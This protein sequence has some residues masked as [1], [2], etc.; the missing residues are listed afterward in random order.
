MK[1]LVS[2]LGKAHDGGKTGY[3]QT[4]Y[5]FD[6]DHAAT[7][8]YFGLA[9]AKYLKSDR[10]IVLGTASSMWG[11]F[12][13]DTADAPG[14]V[15]LD[16]L[17]AAEDAGTVNDTLLAAF[18]PA[19]ERRVGCPVSLVVIPHAR[20]A[21]EQIGI[22]ERLAQEISEGDTIELD[23]TH[24]FRHLP[25]M[26]LVAARYLSKVRKAVVKE[27]YYGAWEM[28][29]AADVS[30]VLRLSGLLSLLDWVDAIASYDKDGDYGVFASLLEAEGLGQDASNTMRRAAFFERTNNPVKAREAAAGVAPQIESLDSP[31][32]GLFRPALLERM[33]WFRAQRRDQWELNLADAQLKRHDY[34]RAALL[35]QEAYVSK[36]VAYRNGDVASFEMRE[37]EREQARKDSAEF[38]QLASL[39]NALAH[40]VRSQGDETAGI[41]ADEASLAAALNR[42]RKR[43]F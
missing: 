35:M 37:K 18:A 30:P 25:M 20:D 31:I 41:L 6:D 14:D 9:L 33:R 34:L 22:L 3:R 32:G 24:G 11:V 42:L 15:D 39:R 7:V 17:I 21:V 27:I 19:I 12:L 2:F 28:R 8:S 38:R 16:A 4:T 36:A 23:V 43:L 29:D 10:L 40:G 13:V 26:G 1:T 5:R